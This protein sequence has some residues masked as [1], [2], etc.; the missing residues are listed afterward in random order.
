MTSAMQVQCSPSWAIKATRKRSHVA[1][2][3]SISDVRGQVLFFGSL[4]GPLV[5]VRGRKI[6]VM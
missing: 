5:L 3:L 6:L 4:Q 2:I 1:L